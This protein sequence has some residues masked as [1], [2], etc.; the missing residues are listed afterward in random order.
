MGHSYLLNAETN[1]QIVA[2]IMTKIIPLLEE[3]FYNDIQ[4]VRFVLNENAT[5]K[6]P[7]YIEDTDAKEA[8][9]NYLTSEDIDEEDKTFFVIDSQIDTIT[10]D[11][12]CGKY[13]KH[14]LGE[15]EE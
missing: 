7:F 15:D 1:K 6:Y 3:Y 8:F 12:I 10:D 11:D 9:Q 2:A 4:K 14:L 5:T 13:L